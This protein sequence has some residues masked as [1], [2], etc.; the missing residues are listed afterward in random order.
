[1]FNLFGLAMQVFAWENSA[2]RFGEDDG[3]SG[4]LF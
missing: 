1:M 2:L 4:P 3:E